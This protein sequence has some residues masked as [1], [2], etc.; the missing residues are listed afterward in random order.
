MMNGSPPDFRTALMRSS[1]EP[2]VW[3]GVLPHSLTLS[4]LVTL[5][6]YDAV[7]VPSLAFYKELGGLSHTHVALFRYHGLKPELAL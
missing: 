4:L 2:P 7:P 1:C 6:G 3:V 5:G